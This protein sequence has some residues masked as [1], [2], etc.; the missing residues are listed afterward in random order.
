[1]TIYVDQVIKNRTD[2]STGSIV[3]QIM[4]AAARSYVEKFAPE[5]ESAFMQR[6]REEIFRNVVPNN[7]DEQTFRQG[8]TWEL[9]KV[10]QKYIEKNSD[11]LEIEMKN[12]IHHE[13]NLLSL[14]KFSYLIANKINIEDIIKEI[15]KDFTPSIK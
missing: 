15:L 7:S 2:G 1:M 8:L 9:Q 11:I 4:Q 12:T 6:Y 5:F 14:D 10:A 13:A 3:D